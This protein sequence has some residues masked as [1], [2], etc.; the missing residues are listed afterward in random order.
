MLI[1]MAESCDPADRAVAADLL[2]TLERR[3]TDVR[4]A[5]DLHGTPLVTWAHPVSFAAL[6]AA[7][8]AS[9]HPGGEAADWLSA[10]A[11]QSD[12]S[13]SYYGSAW[14]AL[15]EI[16]LDTDLLGSCTNPDGG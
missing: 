13:P 1:R 16:M 11:R 2:P 14:V 10:A 7:A 5:Y 6:A 15:T 9:G 8:R 4:A 12:D 3:A